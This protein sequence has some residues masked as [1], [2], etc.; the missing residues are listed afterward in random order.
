MM[1]KAILKITAAASVALSITVFAYGVEKKTS[2]PQDK[3]SDMI[4]MKV[5][6]IVV[7]PN[8]TPAVLLIEQKGD[9]IVAV[10]IGE[11]EAMAII[12]RMNRQKS[13]RPMTLD[14]LEAILKEFGGKIEKLEIDSLRSGVFLG[15]LYIIKKGGERIIFDTRPSDSIGLCLGAMAP[16]Y[17]SKSVVAKSGVTEEELLKKLMLIKPEEKQKKKKPKGEAL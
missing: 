12:R 2:A 13:V 9:K 17:V 8:G 7:F 4:A 15:K 6:D 3:N 11:L 5:K 14:L 16:I 1:I 10:W